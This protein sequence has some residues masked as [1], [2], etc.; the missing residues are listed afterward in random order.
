MHARI[1]Y[2]NNNNNIREF[3]RILYL[4]IFFLLQFIRNFCPNAF[5]FIKSDHGTTF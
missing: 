4:R 3:N 5:M 2:G 1:Q